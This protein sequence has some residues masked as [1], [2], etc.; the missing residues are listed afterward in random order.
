MISTSNY[1]A[2][3]FGVR[4][5]MPGFIAKKL[6][7]QLIFLE[8]ES[9]KYKEAS[10][11]V[12]RIMME[13][14]PNLMSYSLDEF[15]LDLTD[16]TDNE[17]RRRHDDDGDGDDDKRALLSTEACRSTGI[18]C[19]KRKVGDIEAAFHD[20]EGVG[21]E[22][23]EEED[24]GEEA[25]IASCGSRT[26]HI[27]TSPSISTEDG[28]RSGCRSGGGGGGG[29]SVQH[30]RRVACEIVEDMRRRVCVATGGLTCSAGELQSS[31]NN[32]QAI[33]QHIYVCV[34]GKQRCDIYYGDCC[35]IINR[36]SYYDN[37]LAGIANNSF[38]AKIGADQNKP[39]GQFS[40]PPSRESILD[41]LESLPCRKIPGIETFKCLLELLVCCVWIFPNL[42]L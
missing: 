11:I 10:D 38:L 16:Y 3:T 28:C 24:G 22:G 13:Y 6:C 18:S 26:A 32:T 27:T 19:G 40:L 5:A 30:R 36:L 12:K 17:I 33:L 39:D 21:E 1:V 20:D 9:S 23:E 4:S 29:V 41:F 35:T 37:V 7:P 34:V 15:F 31:N 42:L 8:H 14:D 25:A 2:R